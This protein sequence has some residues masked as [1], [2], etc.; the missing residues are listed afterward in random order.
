MKHYNSSSFEEAEAQ[1]TAHCYSFKQ[2]HLRLMS[3]ET[4]TIN[5]MSVAL[6]LGQMCLKGDGTCFPSRK[7]IASRAKVSLRTVSAVLNSLEEKGYIFREERHRNDG[8]LTSSLYRVRG[9]KFSKANKVT[10]SATHAPGRAGDAPPQGNRCTTSNKE[11]LT[12]KSNPSTSTQPVSTQ[13]ERADNEYSR[14]QGTEGKTRH[15][16]HHG[17]GVQFSSLKEPELSKLG[18]DD[19]HQADA[20]KEARYLL[21]PHLLGIG[22]IADM[23]ATFTDFPHE[24]PKPETTRE[25]AC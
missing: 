7:E 8:S 25:L 17:Q 12:K 23:E 2:L 10:S 14:I 21:D 11:K 19:H 1:A 13:E 3:D 5:E 15:H 24:M 4:I 16:Y 20:G 22:F 6:A 9:M 18:R